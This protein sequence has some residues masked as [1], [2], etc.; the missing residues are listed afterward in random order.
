MAD[1]FC[2]VRGFD[3][4]TLPVVSFC[5]VGLG[6]FSGWIG[7]MNSMHF[8]WSQHLE[9]ARTVG[10]AGDQDRGPALALMGVGLTLLLRDL[11]R[12]L[13]LR[14]GAAVRGPRT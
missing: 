13:H 3:D 8:S 14:T 10:A 5:F 6:F 11:E 9:L 12:D 4:R 2:P 7:L 1:V